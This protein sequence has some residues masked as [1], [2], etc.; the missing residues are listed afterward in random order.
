MGCFIGGVPLCGEFGRETMWEEVVVEAEEG[1][2]EAS[3]NP[4]LAG[5][6]FF[7]SF[8]FFGNQRTTTRF[9]VAF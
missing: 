1:F 3:G 9:G 6:V 4:L 7:S 8:F 2:L 5:L